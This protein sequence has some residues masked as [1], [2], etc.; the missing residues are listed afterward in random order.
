[1]A[2]EISRLNQENYAIF[3]QL[4]YLE[5][6]LNSYGGADVWAAHQALPKA[7]KE[8]EEAQAATRAA[9]E[10]KNNMLDE[11]WQQVQT[12]KLE[13]LADIEAT[14]KELKSGLPSLQENAVKL[15]LG[16]EDF[17]HP[18]ESYGAL[19][20]SLR[21]LRE[22][23]KKAASN[24]SAVKPDIYTELPATAA[25]NKQLR[26]NMAKLVLRSFNVEAENIIK[27]VTAANIQSSADKLGRAADAIQ[28]LTR[29]FEVEISR[30]YQEMKMKELELAGQ[31]EEARKLD[32]EE[33]RELRE[34]M[35]EQAKVEAELEAEKRRL[36]KELKHYES[37]LQKIE[38]VGDETRAAELQEE[39]LRIEAGIADVDYRKANERA[40][41]VYVISNI[42]SFGERMVKIGLT[43]RLEP[44][45]R[46][47]ELGD[48]SVPFNFDV[49]A[50]FFAEDAV[51][52]E[53][54]LHHAFADRKVN[55]INNR[56]EFFYATPAEVKEKLTEI[57]GD[58]LEFIEEPQAEQF[59]AS[60]QLA[61]E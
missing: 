16:L 7:Q 38:A 44:M 14:V 59:K 5:N 48:A 23:M 1:M 46:I 33:K 29:P 35:R 11:A 47:R 10:E 24:G 42:G 36:E 26:N 9:E 21:T 22:Q 41:Y 19:Q 54:E 4:R 43:R 51:S 15:T 39:I 45:D 57:Q 2:E 49:H 37:V 28:K 50:L 34:A 3:Q 18:A 8:L 40:G 58:L 27:S 52:V 6:F 31:V 60:L 20:T 12:Y 53:T 25:K 61:A 30:S 56:R 55:K 17:A 32:R 13:Q